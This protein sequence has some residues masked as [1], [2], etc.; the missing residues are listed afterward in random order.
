MRNKFI[1]FS[2]VSTLLLQQDAEKLVTIKSELLRSL[3]SYPVDKVHGR[4]MFVHKH[5]KNRKIIYGALVKIIKS[6]HF[7]FQQ[8][9]L[10]FFPEVISLLVLFF[11]KQ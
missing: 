11:F 6:S 4:N 7:F 3:P 9:F 8:I 1:D 2:K 5:I 10:N